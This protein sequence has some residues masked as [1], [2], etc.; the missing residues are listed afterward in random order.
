MNEEKRVAVLAGDEADNEFWRIQP[1]VQACGVRVECFI[2]ENILLEWLRKSP[3]QPSMIALSATLT[4]RS[5]VETISRVKALAEG[6]PVVA[7]VANATHELERD[8]RR[9]GIF[10]Y[11]VLPTAPELVAEVVLSALKASKVRRRRAAG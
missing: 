11:M 3:V 7:A 9:A 5:F 2:S 6:T 1:F 10:Y 4:R 8:V